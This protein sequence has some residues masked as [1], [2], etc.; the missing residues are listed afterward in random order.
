MSSN[1]DNI[2]TSGSS[3]E[4]TTDDKAA[5]ENLSSDGEGWVL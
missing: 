3:T 5:G 4:G 2:N 1:T